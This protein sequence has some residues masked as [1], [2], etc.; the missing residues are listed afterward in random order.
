ME[1]HTETRLSRGSASDLL[2]SRN[3]ADIHLLA[4]NYNSIDFID[5]FLESLHNFR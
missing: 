3:S 5:G 2:F 4:V 1:K